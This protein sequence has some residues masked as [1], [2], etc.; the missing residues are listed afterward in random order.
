M[1]YLKAISQGVH[2]RM[3]NDAALAAASEPCQSSAPPA[4]TERDLD[5]VVAR[6]FRWLRFPPAIEP[7]FQACRQ[8]RLHPQSLR[9][10]LLLTAMFDAVL[11]C[12]YL[13]VPD[14][15]K[16]A[17]LLRL[18]V[19]TPLIVMLNLLKR[20]SVASGLRWDLEVSGTAVLNAALTLYL[21]GK[22][23][24]P[25]HSYYQVALALL[26]I[27]CNVLMRLRFFAGVATSLIVVLMNAGLSGVFGTALPVMLFSTCILI[28]TSI[29]T[30]MA[31]YTL[32]QQERRN[33]LY[34]L[35]EKV[36]T[37][38]LIHENADLLQLSTLDPL[39]SIANR[40]YFEKYMGRTWR[41][42]RASS[43]P[44]SVLVADVDHFKQFNDRHGHFMGD[45]A[46]KVVATTLRGGLRRSS[47][48][49]ARYGGEEF[50][51]VLPGMS[52]DDAYEVAERLR[53]A[54]E[55]V[56][57]KRALP[58]CTCKLSISVGIATMVPKG[59]NSP[60]DLVKRADAAMYVAK[61]QGRNRTC[62]ASEGTNAASPI[63][64]IY[65]ATA[66]GFGTLSVRH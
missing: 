27:N 56:D 4:I 8:K 44:V 42:M 20:R 61:A 37:D 64:A 12:D 11:V 30:L 40:R 58:G 6:G 7:Q 57:I 21:V 51:T 3:E 2:F 45:A 25:Y 36:R 10:G 9:M 14:V 52:Y 16:T 33:Y 23:H 46:L 19:V 17:L 38:D 48:L 47:D 34:M 35:K 55:H 26:L 60:V 43:M 1:F 31:N 22:S 24:S 15:F 50:V 5:A 39:T 63:A 49:L 59:E 29:S 53:Q 32:D 18:G 54:V 66:D 65:S 28:M 13:I 41:L 62:G